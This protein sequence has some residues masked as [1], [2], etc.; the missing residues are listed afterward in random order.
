MPTPEAEAKS[1]HDKGSEKGSE[2]AVV[3]ASVISLAMVAESVATADRVAAG[4]G[5]RGA[6]ADD[7]KGQE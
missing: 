6:M 4:Y 3:E 1:E 2:E 7:G 5:S